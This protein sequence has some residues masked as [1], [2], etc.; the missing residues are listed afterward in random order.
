M[1]GVLQ[2]V[3]EAMWE[4]QV[5]EPSSVPVF[6]MLDTPGDRVPDL[7]CL[8]ERIKPTLLSHALG[9]GTD[10]LGEVGAYRGDVLRGP[11]SATCALVPAC[12]GRLPSGRTMPCP[13]LSASARNSFL[14]V[15]RPGSDAPNSLAVIESY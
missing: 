11:V 15:S 7:G 4:A 5:E 10:H 1:G 6:S 14:G 9:H 2:A 13:R 8:S 3:D 12:T